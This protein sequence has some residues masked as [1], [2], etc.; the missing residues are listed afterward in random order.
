VDM[1]VISAGVAT[2]NATDAES[3]KLPYQKYLS[4]STIDRKRAHHVI[5]TSSKHL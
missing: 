4:E 5:C 3:A 2:T 1:T